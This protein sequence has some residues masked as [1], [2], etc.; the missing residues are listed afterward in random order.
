MYSIDT[1]YTL[2]RYLVFS[3]TFTE[4]KVQATNIHRWKYPDSACRI[5][6]CTRA[7]VGL[8]FAQLSAV[9][10]RFSYRIFFALKMP[11]YWDGGGRW[12]RLRLWA[13]L[14]S[15]R[16]SEKLSGLRTMWAKNDVSGNNNE[17][18]FVVILATKAKKK[19]G[20]LQIGRWD[21]PA[22]MCPQ[23]ATFCQ[24]HIPVLP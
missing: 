6:K 23:L 14:G 17:K 10:K 3:H 15:S 18:S 1:L 16:S 21:K 24:S 11:L 12:A 5:H 7:Q 9:Y 2:I 4:F 19:N 13:P 22:A 20:S 8:I